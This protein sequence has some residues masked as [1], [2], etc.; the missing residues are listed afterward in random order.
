M[1]EAE[2]KRFD[3]T[4][5]A[6][7]VT[8]N[9]KVLDIGCGDGTLLSILKEQRSVDGRGIEL[10]QKGV[11]DCVARGLSVIQGNADHDLV[12]YP[13]NSFDFVILSQTIQA[14]HNPRLV[15]EELL[16]I[17]K[18]CIVSAPNFG[19]WRM[20]V[21]LLL[22][23]RMPITKKLPHTWYDTPNIH[24]CT[25]YD[26]TQLCHDVNANIERVTPVTDTGADISKTVPQF[27]WNILAQQAV[28][29]L[30]EKN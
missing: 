2:Q 24:F 9:A 12:H 17:G 30:T 27:L 5:I 3:L 4:V 19:H 10:S 22:Q 20:R 13:D 25:L 18:Y 23:G 8:P 7:L 21:Q 14:T 16:R 29:L 15:L 11:N 26:F 6:D 28:F 1:T